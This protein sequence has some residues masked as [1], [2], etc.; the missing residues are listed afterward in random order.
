MMVDAVAI[1]A[2]RKIS[3][4]PVVSAAGNPVGLIDITDVVGVAAELQAAAKLPVSAAIYAA[5]PPRPNHPM[6][7]SPILPR[8]LS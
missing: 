7:V 8:E 2:E 6:F 4:L 1:M 5:A 3:E